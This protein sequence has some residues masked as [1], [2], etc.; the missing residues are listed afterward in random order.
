[1][2]S[3]WMR[4]AITASASRIASS[5]LGATA[6][7]RASMPAGIN[8]GGPATVTD[9]PTAR[10]PNIAERATRECA[11]SPTIAMRRPSNRPCQASRSVNRSSSP[12][13]G[14]SCAPSPALIT[15]ASRCCARYAA[16]PADPCRTTISSTRIDTTVRSVSSS[17][18]PLDID[19]PCVNSGT[20]IAPSRC[21]A[22]S[23]D[24]RV[25]VESSK[26]A[27]HTATP[28]SAS[29]TRPARSIAR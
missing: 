7:P 23:N 29:D 4:S 26:N 2:R 8:V 28:R 27:R 25:R 16:A 5:T 21:A 12:C 24:T 11:T 18:S 6:Q 10:R 15:P 20:G 13:V 3:R 14:C 19:E 1:M 9:A 17:V 22:S